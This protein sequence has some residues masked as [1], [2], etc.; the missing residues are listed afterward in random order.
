MS[1]PGSCKKRRMSRKLV[2]AA[3]AV[4]VWCLAWPAPVRADDG[5]PHDD[6]PAV[7]TVQFLAGAAVAF[8]A[9]ESGHLAFDAAFDAHPYVK[10]VEF[11]GIPFFAVTHDVVLSPRREFTVSSAGF[12]VQHATDEWLLARR[13]RGERGR[14]ANGMLAF[15]VLTS[16]GYSM[17]AF[18]KAG[19]YERDTRG[20]AD[21]IR[22][23]ER[24]VG[25]MILAPALLD[26]YR[27]Y[28]PGSAWA[29]WLSRGVKIGGV[30]LVAR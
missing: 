1:G 17:A 26:A 6:S 28:R 4:A 23:D 29:R 7:S 16:V 30:L 12:W 5:R 22:V 3:S 21:S 9:H 2:R 27:Y 14:F 10:K 13:L 25:A 11:G 18:A 15:N 24:A 8:A 20:M 19:P